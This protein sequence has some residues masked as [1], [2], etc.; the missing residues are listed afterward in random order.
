[1]ALTWNGDSTPNFQAVRPVKV[2]ATKVRS[3]N[4]LAYV[5]FTLNFQYN[6]DELPHPDDAEVLS[7]IQPI[8]DG[9]K[10]DGWEFNTFRQE[11]PPAARSIQEV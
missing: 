5:E 10:A 2:G 1:M 8:Y 3:N 11:A 9:M 7:W 4:T 6:P